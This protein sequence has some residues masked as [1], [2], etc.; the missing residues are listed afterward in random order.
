M[1][2]VFYFQV[3][4]QVKT[5]DED[6]SETEIQVRPSS[7]QAFRYDGGRS[8]SC[9]LYSGRAKSPSKNQVIREGRFERVKVGT[10]AGKRALPRNWHHQK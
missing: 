5:P 8:Q 7:S 1:I 2:K 10:K 6:E 4:V 9:F 3:H